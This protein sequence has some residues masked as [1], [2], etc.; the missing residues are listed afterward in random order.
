MNGRNGRLVDAADP[1]R[2]GSLCIRAA[3][4]TRRENMRTVPLSPLV[5]DRTRGKRGNRKTRRS[6]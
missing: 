5:S 3:Y 4:I 1:G 6:H 2:V